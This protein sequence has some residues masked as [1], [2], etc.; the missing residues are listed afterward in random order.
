MRSLL[1]DLDDSQPDVGWNGPAGEELSDYVQDLL[2][3][4]GGASGPN[5]IG[6]TVHIT[7]LLFFALGEVFDA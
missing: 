5:G 1:N 6:H 3:K 7:V 2:A 4:L